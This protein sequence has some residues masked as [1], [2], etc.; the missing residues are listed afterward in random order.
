MVKAGI[1]ANAELARR[2]DKAREEGLADANYHVR[3]NCNK[4]WPANTDEEVWAVIGRHP[5][6][7]IYTVSSPKGLPVDQFIPF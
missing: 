1:Q 6:G 5:L 2:A 7:S 3:I 4:T